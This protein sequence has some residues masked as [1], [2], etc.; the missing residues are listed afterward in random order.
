VY[1][2]DE[3]KLEN[4]SAAVFLTHLDAR[5]IGSVASP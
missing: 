5:S 2:F 4:R 3:W 1:R